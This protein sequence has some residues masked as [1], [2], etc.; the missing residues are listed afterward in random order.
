MDAREYPGGCNVARARARACV[1]AC[2]RACAAGC[3]DLRP[4]A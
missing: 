2:A 1:R 4:G 3:A